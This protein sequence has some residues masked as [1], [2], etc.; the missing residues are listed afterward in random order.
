MGQLGGIE[1]PSEAPQASILAGVLRLYEQT[2]FVRQ[3]PKIELFTVFLLKIF[4]KKNAQ[5][6]LL[7]LELPTVNT[8]NSCK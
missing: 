8:I 7:N 4:P 1:P 5:L 6:Q 3:P 2:K